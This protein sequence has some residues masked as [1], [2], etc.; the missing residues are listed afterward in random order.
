MDLYGYVPV[1]GNGS[2]CESSQQIC[3]SSVTIYAKRL[4]RISFNNGQVSFLEGASRLDINGGKSNA[5]VI[6]TNKLGHP[7]K[8]YLFNQ[9]YQSGRLFLQAVQVFDAQM[10]DDAG[11]EVNPQKYTFV[12]NQN[13]LPPRNSKDQ[14]YWGYFNEGN[15]STLIPGAIIQH[16]GVS[17][18]LEGG[19]RIPN[20][21]ATKAGVLEQIVYPTGGRLEL[22]YELNDA[23]TGLP[24]F[25][26]I[27]RTYF[28]SYPVPPPEDD[29]AG[30]FTISTCS[31]RLI[32]LHAVATG[33]ATPTDPNDPSSNKQ[34]WHIYKFSAVDND[35]TELVGSLGSL[36]EPNRSDRTF[37]LPAGAY[38]VKIVKPNGAAPYDAT[39]NLDWKDDAADCFKQPVGGLRVR[40]TRLYDG[41]SSNAVTTKYNYTLFN[42]NSKSSGVVANFPLYEYKVEDEVASIYQIEDEQDIY[43]DRCLLYRRSSMSTQALSSTGVS[44]V[45]Y[46]NVTVSSISGS[47]ILGKTEYTFVSPLEQPD[48]YT[49]FFPFAPSN[50]FDWKRGQVD[51]IQVFKATETGG[52]EL[53]QSTKNEYAAIA[54]FNYRGLKAGIDK[55][56]LSYSFG[57]IIN[58]SVPNEQ[59]FS[60]ISGHNFAAK[61]TQTTYDQKSQSRKMESIQENGVNPKNYQIWLNTGTNSKQEETQSKIYYSCDYQIGSPSNTFAS[62]IKLLQTKNIFTLP[63]ETYQTVKDKSN[64]VWVISG[65]LFKYNDFGM[66]ENVYDLSL[67]API[68]F[69]S[70]SPSFVNSGGEFQFDSRYRLTAVIHYNDDGNISET[71]KANDLHTKFLWGYNNELPI[72]ECTNCNDAVAYTSFEHNAPGNWIIPSEARTAGSMTGT[73]SFSLAHGSLSKG[74]LLASSTYLVSYWSNSGAYIVTGS[75]G[76]TKQ[77]KS[78]TLNGQSWT[79]FEHLVTG[80]TQVHIS[81]SG[82][83]DELRLYPRTGMMTTYSHIPLV[84]VSSK[85]DV[86]N[87]ISHFIYDVFGRLKMIRDGE[88]NTVKTVEYK[89][90]KQH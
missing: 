34:Q 11:C 41:I 47:K 28:Y 79:Y 51:L 21:S 12:Y 82:A 42:D 85:C 20:E 35:F 52:F 2:G 54:E 17:R 59:F 36:T 76:S 56:R 37:L 80:V 38:R 55:G 1:S 13:Q 77:G 90:Q 88:G 40:E 33:V 46:R 5:G 45:G 57:A 14:D 19:N 71:F 27:Q 48:T 78:V 69:S 6:V 61:S 9:I 70:F 60:I 74:D 87:T 72:A 49:A 73:Q 75:Q 39:I 32:P 53:I 16:N 29:F 58:V 68:L 62:S 31:P 65:R 8:K 25:K 43:I 3:S 18:I 63:V 26:S 89:F 86:N 7:V 67:K 10:C 4:D 15:N 83:I 81:G 66:I 64:V 23:S 30:N 22:D 24:Y 44:A 84:G 50:S